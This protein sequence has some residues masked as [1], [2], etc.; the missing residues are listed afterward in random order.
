MASHQLQALN[1]PHSLEEQAQRFREAVGSLPCH[2]SHFPMPALA[3][4]RL[5]LGPGSS[6]AFLP[7]EKTQGLRLGR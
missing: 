1:P 3:P 6:S 4:L 7:K 2:L 5:P